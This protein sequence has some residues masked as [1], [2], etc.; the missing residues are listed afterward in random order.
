MYQK[1]KHILSVFDP[2]EIGYSIGKLAG[3]LKKE[4]KARSGKADKIAKSK[5]AW[6]KRRALSPMKVCP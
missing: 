3:L 5:A 6:K 1:S 2:Y 4:Y